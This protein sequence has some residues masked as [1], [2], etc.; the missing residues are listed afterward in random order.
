MENK[1]F[2]EL[3]LSVEILDAINEMGFIEASP[4]QSQA[5]PFLLEGKDLIGQAQTGTGKTAAFSIPALEKIDTSLNAT[6]V[7][8]LCP[9]RELA[10]QVSN[11]IK[12]LS[13]FQTG[14]QTFPVY[15]GEPIDKQIKAL[16][17]GTHVVVGTPGRIID[18]IDRG[19]LR[20]NNVKMVVL[21]EAD[22]MLDM[23]FREDIERILEEV[24][25]E[26]QTVFF[27]ATMPKSIMD[28]TKRY[29][30][31]PQLVK[32]TREELTT[33]NT[34][35]FYLEV[36][37]NL[38]VEG[39]ARLV[40]F[41]NLQLMLVFCNTK[42]KVDEVVEQL[43]AKGFGAEGLHGDMTQVQ[44][45]RV[46]QKFRSGYISMLV[47]T[48]VAARGIDV[49]GVDAVFNYDLPLDP[50]YYV[51]R[52]GRT[53]RAG[54]SGKSFTF[55]SG[56]ERGKLKDL[57]HFTKGTINKISVPSSDEL[58]NVRKSA[59]IGEIKSN[60][61]EEN[62]IKFNKTIDTLTAEGFSE[63]D[64]IAALIKMQLG[65][66]K[67]IEE[68]VVFVEEPAERRG[69]R[70]RNDRSDR[71]R[72][73]ARGE[74]RGDSRGESRGDSRGGDRKRERGYTGT[75]NGKMARIFINLGK[76][77]K[78]RPGDIVGAISGETGIPG[79]MIG[80]IDIY[81]KFSFVEVPKQ[82]ASKVV[83]IMNKN[84]IKGLKVNFEIAK[85]PV[86]G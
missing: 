45:N 33:A 2:E 11:E 1:K 79:R 17:K 18:H 76:S 46:M 58:A 71:D 15:G 35:Q 75:N 20:L 38:R 39:I 7:L 66:A 34:E 19:T 51:H 27:S 36:R 73:G 22:E 8:V 56:R 72:R 78:I 25:E 55:I 29:Q 77:S 30:K 61:E 59:L 82:E 43:Q 16:K 42:L 12:K 5:I 37:Q 60:I 63:R 14:I 81:D 50:E 70:D 24:P 57:L 47:A 80:S 23:G 4:I 68:D 85:S 84:Q 28:M 44:R 10:L 65:T 21:D 48:D 83:E 49:T 6:Q 9:T 86:M 31:N 53:G 54:N 74:S 3:S 26:R 40:K 67:D 52:I 41:H 62:L 64:I 69:S 13:K 32:V